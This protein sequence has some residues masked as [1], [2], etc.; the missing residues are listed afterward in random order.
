MT[1]PCPT[2]KVAYPNPQTAHRALDRINRRTTGGRGATVY[3]CSDC[4][5][6]HLGSKRTEATE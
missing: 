3:Q 6:W 5:A 4:R 2:G 1:G